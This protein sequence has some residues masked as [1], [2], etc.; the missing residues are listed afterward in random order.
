VTESLEAK[1]DSNGRKQTPKEEVKP[2]GA[3]REPDVREAAQELLDLESRTLR[4]SATLGA[5]RVD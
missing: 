3:D 5:V 2:S 1:P 4:L